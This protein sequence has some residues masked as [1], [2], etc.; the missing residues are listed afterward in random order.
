MRCRQRHIR[1]PVDVIAGYAGCIYGIATALADTGDTPAAAV[2]GY[3][4]IV[5]ATR[6]VTTLPAGHVEMIRWHTAAGIAGR[7]AGY[8]C[9]R[10]WL[11]WLLPA[12]SWLR[13][14]V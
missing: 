10:Y 7:Y 5:K 9:C 14:Y 2:I 13:H 1:W 4:F 6:A 11:H 8:G 12:N 3:T